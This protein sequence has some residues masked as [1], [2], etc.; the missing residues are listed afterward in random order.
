MPYGG[1]FWREVQNTGHTIVFFV[2]TGLVV[3]LL[4]D[5]VSVL[6]KSQKSLLITAATLSLFI[7]I[8]IELV[9]LTIENDGNKEDVL[10][11]VGGIL[12]G[13]A[14]YAGINGNDYK[15]GSN[16]NRIFKSKLVVASICILT[17]FLVPLAQGGLAM[18]QRQI[19]FPVVF[20]PSAG[21]T[22]YF[23]E[24][25]NVK[26][27][28]ESALVDALMKDNFIHLKLDV[29]MYP[30]VSMDEPF[31][32]WTSY[33]VLVLP[34]YSENTTTFDLV[35]RVHDVN[36][37][38]QYRDRFNKY[39]TVKNGINY[40]RIPLNEIEESPISRKLDMSNIRNLAIF[41]DKPASPVRLYIG[42]IR[43]E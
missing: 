41:M 33:S 17:V 11:D 40:F 25:N 36:H 43:L 28:E 26:K 18:I 29:A 2:M 27:I 14:M 9:Q 12:A 37:N 7:A 35:L 19:A 32:D 38:N 6:R 30:G 21:W 15:H 4:R 20:D 3:I 23:S 1:L 13:L 42:P 22:D 34:I 5:N 24:F 8:A 39:I 31:P 16:N 10:R